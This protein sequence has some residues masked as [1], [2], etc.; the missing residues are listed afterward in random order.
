L[1]KTPTIALGVA[2]SLALAGGAVA[3]SNTTP[4]HTLAMSVISSK[5]G[6]TTKPK[7][8]QVKLAIANNAEAKTTAKKIEVLFPKTIKINTKGFKKCSATTLQDQGMEACP[9]GSKVGT[10]KAS[11]VVNPS[12]DMPAPIKFN[13]TFFVGSSSTLTIFLQ[14]LGDDGK[15]NDAINKVLIGKIQTGGGGFGK[16]LSISIPEDL[17]QPAPGVYSAL[18]T[19]TTSIKATTGSG[20]SKHGIL[21]STG[22]VASKFAFK[23][24]LFYAPNPN[25]PAVSKS[26]ATDKVACTKA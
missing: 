17:Q 3:Q 2:A 24:R 26:E 14:S 18:K 22:C 12:S 25:P 1:R 13:N 8:V 6:T 7:S 5:A 20:S 16:K 15:P 21:E 19:I 11:A 9:S 23:S 10:G 4:S